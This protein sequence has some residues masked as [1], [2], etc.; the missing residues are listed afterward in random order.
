MNAASRNNV[1]PGN[2]VKSQKHLCKYTHQQ[3]SEIFKKI[4]SK[5]QTQEVNIFFLILFLIF[6]KKKLPFY[7][8]F[9][10]IKA[11]TIQLII[12]KVKLSD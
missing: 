10:L 5:T 11:H 4:G 3:L 7:R 1:K 8:I 9:Q 12:N 6:K 2:Q